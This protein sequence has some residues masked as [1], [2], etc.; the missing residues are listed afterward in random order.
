MK[1]ILLAMIAG[2]ILTAV[3]EAANAQYFGDDSHETKVVQNSDLQTTNRDS[4][5]STGESQLESRTPRGPISDSEITVI[6]GGEN[7]TGTVRVNNLAMLE[8][9]M[10]IC[11]NG[12]ELIGLIWGAGLLFACFRKMHQPGIARSLAWALVPIILGL[13]TPPAINWA[14]RAAQTADLF[15]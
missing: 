10:N 5:S 4:A 9:L 7:K 2:S 13:C 14:L 8:A 15:C 1:S 6:S 3:T 11:A 12:A